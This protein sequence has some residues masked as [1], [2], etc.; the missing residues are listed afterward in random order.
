[1]DDLNVVYILYSSILKDRN[2]NRLNI[3]KKIYF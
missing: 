1:M 3:Y 2:F